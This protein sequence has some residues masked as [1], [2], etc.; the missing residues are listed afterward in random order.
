MKLKSFLL[1]LVFVSAC[2]TVL[3]QA[4]Y[5]L[6]VCDSSST[7]EK[8]VGDRI[9]LH[10]PKDAVVKKGRDVDFPIMQFGLVQRRRAFLMGVSAT[11]S[12]ISEAIQRGHSIDC[13]SITD[14]PAQKA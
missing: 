12:P 3:A 9:K 13:T 4:Q 11:A 8:A 7:S 6:A 14:E 10:P 5:S 1:S 2:P